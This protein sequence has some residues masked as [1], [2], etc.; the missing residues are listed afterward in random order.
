MPLVNRL[1]DAFFRTLDAVDTARERLDRVLGREPAMTP[2]AWE[3]A[4]AGATDAFTQRP[5][6]TTWS[7]TKIAP[8]KP[9]KAP[10]KVTAKAPAKAAAKNSAKDAQEAKP[11]KVTAKKAAKGAAKGAAKKPARQK[12]SRKGSVDRT[13]ADFDSPR[14]RAVLEQLVATSTPVI[15]EH[16]AIDNKKVLARVVWALGAAQEAGSAQGLTAADA[17]ALL[18]LA[19]GMDVF[20]TNIARACREETD[21]IEEGEP[22]G[23]IKRYRLT[24]AGRKAAAAL[25]LR[26]QG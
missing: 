6:P 24:A 19:A 25:E 21:L 23:R 9:P 4:P 13:G 5:A 18:H 11:A 20:S 12:A 10:A 17:S 15:A 7:E 2:S 26:A 3:A 1:L 14:A 22:D 16:A 8:A